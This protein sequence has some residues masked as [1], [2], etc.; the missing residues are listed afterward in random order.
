[1]TLTHTDA[2]PL[3]VT[4]DAS[5]L[6]DLLRLC[7]AAGV[8]PEVA[9]DAAQARRSWSTASCVVVGGDDLAPLIGTVDRRDGVVITAV[10]PADT[11]L[12]ARAVE[13]GAEGVYLL[14]DDESPVVELLA[15]SSERA[16]HDAAVV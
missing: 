16:D 10:G 6:D 14:P 13:L 2:R 9:A 11:E 5:L 12:W 8:T 7:A 4:S 15:A 1:M 3:V